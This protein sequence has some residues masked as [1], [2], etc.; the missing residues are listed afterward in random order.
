M[1]DGSVSAETEALWRSRVLAWRTSGQSQKVFCADKEF[2]R[3]SL[4]AWST[5]LRQGAS[6]A[7]TSPASRET[8]PLAR[9]VR[10]A[11]SAHVPVSPESIVLECGAVR[12]HLGPECDRAWSVQLLRAL[13]DAG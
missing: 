2:S 5:R 13:R 12:V 4:T 6:S 9:V 10:P 3:H 1:K 7:S 11:T 8:V